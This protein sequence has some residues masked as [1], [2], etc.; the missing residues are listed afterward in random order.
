M[1]SWAGA[2]AD[3]EVKRNMAN[4]CILVYRRSQ[5][6]T[7][8]KKLRLQ[9]ASGSN[10]EEV[11]VSMNIDFSTLCLISVPGFLVGLMAGRFVSG[12]SVQRIQEKPGSSRTVSGRRFFLCL[13]RR[14]AQLR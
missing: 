7:F 11:T 1:D 12:R 13:P 6:M 8:G 4:P 9:M 14:R 3:V 2:V 5:E 10:F